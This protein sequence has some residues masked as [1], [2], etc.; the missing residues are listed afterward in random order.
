MRSRDVQVLAI[1]VNRVHIEQA[2]DVKQ[3]LITQLHNEL[4]IAVIPFEKSL[5]SPTMLEINR[6]LGGKLLFGEDQLSNQADH[7]ITGAM[8]VPNF[9]NYLKE[10]VLI[11]TPGD[12]GDII[13]RQIFLQVI[14]RFQ[15]LYFR[16][17]LNRKNR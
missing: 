8:Q 5:N 11:V 12:R 9:L 13:I 16:R 4:V 10:T 1:V 6:Q 2:E 17:V 15:V 7:F 3:L 14:Q